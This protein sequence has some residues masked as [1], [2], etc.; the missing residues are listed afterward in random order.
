MCGQ[1]D[2]PFFSHS[3]TIDTSKNLS[4]TKLHSNYNGLKVFIKN[5]FSILE[6]V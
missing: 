4:E 2:I 6:K 1:R 3:E 5:F